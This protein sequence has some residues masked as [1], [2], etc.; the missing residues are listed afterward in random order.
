MKT[1]WGRMQSSG[2]Q[3]VRGSVFEKAAFRLHPSNLF[4][5][6]SIGFVKKGRLYPSKFQK[7]AFS[8]FLNFVLNCQREIC[9]SSDLT[10]VHINSHTFPFFSQHKKQFDISRVFLPIIAIQEE[11][12]E[13]DD[14]D[15]FVQIT[16]KVNLCQ[17]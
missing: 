3:P 14:D 9:C 2:A 16:K 8:S 4:F 13:S 10:I 6:A 15:S 11:T 5:Y 12:S 17:T 1:N 7:D